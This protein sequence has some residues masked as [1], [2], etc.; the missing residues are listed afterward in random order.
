M[1]CIVCGYE[2]QPGTAVCPYCGNQQPVN[3]QP[4]MQYG[5]PQQQYGQ[6]PQYNQQPQYSQ[7]PQQQYG[8]QPQMQQQY[9]QAPQQ[10]QYSQVPQQMPS[11][12]GGKKYGVIIAI[13]ICLLVLVGGTV[14]GVIAYK[15]HKAD[16][17]AETEAT[18]EIVKVTEEKTTR[19]WSEASTEE[20]TTTEATTEEP[21]PAAYAEE[22]NVQFSPIGTEGA[23][24]AYAKLYYRDDY[25]DEGEGDSSELQAVD[26]EGVTV[27]D[28]SYSDQIRRVIKTEPDANGMVRYYF[29]EYS[30]IEAHIL[31]SNQS[32]NWIYVPS[33]FTSGIYDYYGGDYLRAIYRSNGFTEEKINRFNI[34]YKGERIDISVTRIDEGTDHRLNEMTTEDTEEGVRYHFRQ[35]SRYVY[36]IECP[37]DYDG[38]VVAVPNDD[39]DKERFDS[40][41]EID[42]E[43]EENQETNGY[44]NITRKMF[45]ENSQ[46]YR[47]GPESYVHVRLSDVAEPYTPMAMADFFS[48]MSYVYDDSFYWV[49]AVQDGDE[50]MGGRRITDPALIEGE[51]ECRI[52][53]NADSEFG[54]GEE[55]NYVTISFSGDE[56]TWTEEYYYC[57]WGENSQWEYCGDDEPESFSGG[58]MNDE[59]E[60]SFDSGEYPEYL[61]IRFYTNDYCQHAVGTWGDG[62]YVYLFRP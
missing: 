11:S 33:I 44:L 20:I 23:G 46:G 8:R 22:N 27:E 21:E 48:N 24:N 12:G 39:V 16:L 35:G 9:R 51:W 15:K 30:I 18:T 59:G 29:D 10:P 3:N 4:Q 50:S 54:Y 34:D 61:K 1:K 45:E 60:L 36:I 38:L 28:C 26:I 5:Q 47:N 57:L 53:Y 42:N 37:E 52:F 43:T 41:S 25:Y 6:A 13:V 32:V 14:V 7:V 2:L 49:G 58:F 62:V 40:I 56:A 17:E 19:E 55:E 31:D